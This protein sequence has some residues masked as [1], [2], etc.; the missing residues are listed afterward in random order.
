MIFYIAHSWALDR[1]R[2]CQTAIVHIKNSWAQET[3]KGNSV[4][5]KLYSEK[6]NLSINEH[7]YVLQ[8]L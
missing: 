4:G 7:L 2:S 5:N 8:N 6:Y 3:D 1:D